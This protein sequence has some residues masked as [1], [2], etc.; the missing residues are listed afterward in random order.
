MGNQDTQLN[1]AK[2]EVT[3]QIRF[4]ES[5]NYYPDLDY[6][7]AEAVMKADYSELK[8][9]Q[10]IVT[11]LEQAEIHE[12]T[13]EDEQMTVMAS[14]QEDHFDECDDHSC[15]CGKFDPVVQL[16]IENDKLKAEMLEPTKRSKGWESELA[17][18]QKQIDALKKSK[19][20][21]EEKLNRAVVEN[22]VK[23]AQIKLLQGKNDKLTA[24][25]SDNYNVSV[26]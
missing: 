4:I 5:Q 23:G 6:D 10:D 3:K 7:K 12:M 16:K 14:D 9:K 13:E 1:K 15:S 19:I 18:Y 21:A 26:L 20:E 2:M 25:L 17:Q 11:E 8:R 22:D 24:Y